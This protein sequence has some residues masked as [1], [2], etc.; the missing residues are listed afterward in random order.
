PLGRLWPAV[1]V[2]LHS[3][4]KRR[5]EVDSSTS[6]WNG[7]CLGV[8]RPFK[9]KV[10]CQAYSFFDSPARQR[11][12]SWS[13]WSIHKTR[14]KELERYPRV[15]YAFRFGETASKERRRHLAG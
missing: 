13:S 10:R 14:S 2:T 4:S 11:R 7:L 5:K 15:S 3:F 12:R 9:P 6:G 8:V 1:R